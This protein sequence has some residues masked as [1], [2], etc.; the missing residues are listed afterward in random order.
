MKKILTVLG[1]RPQF[2]K[3][4]P[5]SDIL[6]NNTSFREIVVHTGQHYDYR[7]SEIFFQELRL[8]RPKYHLGVGGLSNIE[9]ISL[10]L[11]KLKEPILKEKPRLIIVYGDTNSTLAGALSSKMFKIPLAHIEA[12]VR[13]FN[14]HMPEEINRILTDRISDFLFAPVKEAV[15][16]LH[17]EGIRKRVYLVGDVLCDVLLANTDKLK[18][19]FSRLSKEM[20]IQEKKFSLLTLHRQENVDSRSTLKL[21]LRNISKL[22]IKIIFPLHPR[23]KKRIKEFSLKKYL[24]KNI[25]CVEPQSYLNTL[26]LIKYAYSVLTDSGG[27]QRE[28]YIL[29]TPCI[30]LR[31]ETEWWQTLKFGWNTLVYINPQSLNK[32][33]SLFKKIT[34]PAKYENI[35]GDGNASRKIFSRLKK[36]LV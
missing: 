2:I 16:N 30:T 33:L 10:M 28:A 18:D 4:K 24:A 12:G 9:Q 22:P 21:V 19:V 7:M 17:R 6:K 5:L 15:E 32:L 14:L 31:N 13:S 29:K 1:A 23:V 26:S 3:S 25:I 8:S 34:L 20:D 36:I 11:R 27:V 35:F